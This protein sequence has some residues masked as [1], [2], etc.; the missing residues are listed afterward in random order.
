MTTDGSFSWSV[1]TRTDI[2]N[3]SSAC[4]LISLDLMHVALHPPSDVLFKIL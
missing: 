3:R 2:Y 4:D 1:I